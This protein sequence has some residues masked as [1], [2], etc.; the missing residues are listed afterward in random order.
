ML[1]D[2]V[3]CDLLSTFNIQT[4]CTVQNSQISLA[5]C[6]LMAYNAKLSYV[7]SSFSLSEHLCDLYTVT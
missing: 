3:I 1:I 4:F 5:D 6:A 7:M 2:T